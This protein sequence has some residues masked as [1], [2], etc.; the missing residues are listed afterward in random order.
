MWQ[1]FAHHSHKIAVA[2]RE[3]EQLNAFLVL[4]NRFHVA[5]ARILH[6]PPGIIIQHD[7]HGG[8]D[9]GGNVILDNEHI[10]HGSIV[11]V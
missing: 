5:D 4:D 3:L 7:L 2:V 10:I 1:A 6:A 9:V 11:G 8:S